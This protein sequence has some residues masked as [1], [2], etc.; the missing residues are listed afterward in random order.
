MS[1]L[2]SL[3]TITVTD[4]DSPY[5]ERIGRLRERSED[6]P[7]LY[8]IQLGGGERIRLFRDQFE[9]SDPDDE[10]TNEV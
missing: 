3:Y 9:D 6:Q 8:F 10:R 1:E 2:Q 5:V 7:Y 4:P